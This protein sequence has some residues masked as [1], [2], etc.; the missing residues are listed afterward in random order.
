MCPGDYINV[1]GGEWAL[2]VRRRVDVK[3][4]CPTC[5][6]H[7]RR[8]AWSISLFPDH[9]CTGK[10]SRSVN[11]S[12]MTVQNFIVNANCDTRNTTINSRFY[13]MKQRL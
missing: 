2:E 10:R 5:S 3:D 7:Q 8:F 1:R 4:L 12:Q 9:D 6:R 13:E 11:L